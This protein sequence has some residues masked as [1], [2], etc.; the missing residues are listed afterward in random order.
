MSYNAEPQS[1]TSPPGTLPSYPMPAYLNFIPGGVSNSEVSEE[2]SYNLAAY[3]QTSENNS[4]ILPG[5][6]RRSR[7]I[8]TP[9]TVVH[10]AKIADDRLRQYA[11]LYSQHDPST[12]HFLP[13]LSVLADAAFGRL[14]GVPPDS[15]K[16]WADARC[17][18]L[19]RQHS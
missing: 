6:P 10:K 8:Q 16:S 5:T 11:L 9:D 3:S 7:A 2:H 13:S 1:E 14:T 4:G 19:R 18:G 12:P 17:R 15:A